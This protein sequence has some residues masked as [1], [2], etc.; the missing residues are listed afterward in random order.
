[1]DET[2]PHREGRRRILMACAA[3]PP[4]IDGGGPIS[5]MMVA[6]LLIAAG[7]EVE[8]VNV[9]GEDRHE[10]FDGVP[11]RRLKSLNVD[12]NYRLPRPAW[13][14]ALWHALEN[15][16]PRAFFV[17]R[18]EMR[19]FRPDL[20]LTDSIENVNVAT[21]AAAKSLGLPTVHILR[22]AFLLCWK[23]SMRKG[24][25]NCGRA[26]GSCQASS[27]GKKLTSRFV[28]AV[29]GETQFIVGRHLEH[30][31]FPNAT[32]HVVPGAIKEI[33]ARAPREAP[34]GR[35]VRFGF[36]GVL[37]PVKGLDTLAAAAHRLA[38]VDAEFLIAGT[39]FG[40]YA[41][42]LAATFP[43]ASTRFLGWTKPADFFP[44]VDVLVVPSLFREP[45]GRVAIEAFAHGVPVIAARSGGLPETIEP[46]HNG[47]VFA[48]GDDAEL[49]AKLAAITA[50][51]EI[52][53]RLSA[54]A[55]A[56]AE[57]YLTPRIA[58]GFD[59]VFASLDQ[60][61]ARA[62]RLVPHGAQA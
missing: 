12:W 49:A 28:D 5:A 36:I 30:A 54:G 3:F 29:V 26:C 57:K 1:M 46:G 60:R 8:V 58:A 2:T 38:G 4:F 34:K 9:S 33:V 41:D 15:F 6:K 61:P 47:D 24:G 51:P 56:S 11:V 44:Q 21:W 19:R 13:K 7:H 39:G 37:D 17:M 53:E 22:S 48:P 31:Y 27:Y 45:F 40:D 55:L 25:D 32:A 62:P 23:A 42:G 16:N 52:I 20:V 50:Q 59:Q 10:I 18:R 35:P 14:K 43:V